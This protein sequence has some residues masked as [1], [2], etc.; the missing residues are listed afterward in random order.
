M[1]PRQFLMAKSQEINKTFFSR[2][3]HHH[4]NMTVTI[5]KIGGSSITNKA[6]EETLDQEAL[7]W[8]A[9]LIASS[10]DQSSLSS[11]HIATSESKPKFVVVHGAV[12]VHLDTIRPN[13]MD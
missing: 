11:H 7:E 3:Q 13:D 2:S 8:F 10:V 9:K 12:P 5:L 6:K 4:S 1:P